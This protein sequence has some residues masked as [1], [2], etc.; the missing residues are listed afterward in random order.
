MPIDK[1]KIKTL[2]KLVDNGIDTEKKI[3]ALDLAAILGI[4]E[5][6]VPEIQVIT[7]LQTAIKNRRVISYLSDGVDEDASKKAAE[8]TDE[9]DEEVTYDRYEY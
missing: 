2:N 1:M 5:I 9:T 7:N 4:P 6:T 3:T 8:V